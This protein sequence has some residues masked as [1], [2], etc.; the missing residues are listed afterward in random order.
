MASNNPQEIIQAPYTVFLSTG[1]GTYPAITAS[2]GAEWAEL[3]I[4][5][6]QEDGTGVSVAHSQAG[7][8]VRV[9]GYTGPVKWYRTSEDQT[10]SFRLLDVKPS[11]Y[12][13]ALSG[14]AETQTG[15]TDKIGLSRS[16]NTREVKLLIRGT[17]SLLEGGNAQYE[18]P[19]AVQTGSPTVAY[20]K[21]KATG[22]DFE[23]MTL[24]DTSAT[25]TGEEFGRLIVART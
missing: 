6:R 1:P 4:T 2:P 12:K 14:D 19:R 18:I 23:F 24:V 9:E 15:A 8:S 10:V 5:T 22:L 3:G 25:A 13:H 11:T 21:G 20:S 16:L 7:Q 17:S